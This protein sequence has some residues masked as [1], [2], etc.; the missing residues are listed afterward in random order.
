[1]T[2]EIDQR[3]RERDRER[4]REIDKRPREREVPG[5]RGR[6]RTDVRQKP[7]E[8]QGSRM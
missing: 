7:R 4:T 2:G 1:M 5:E 8:R 6:Q 3:P